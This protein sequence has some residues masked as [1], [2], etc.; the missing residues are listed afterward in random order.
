MLG[1]KPGLVLLGPP[2]IEGYSNRHSC[3]LNGWQI[4]LYCTYG[5]V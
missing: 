4:G 2:Q 3:E 5:E 1:E